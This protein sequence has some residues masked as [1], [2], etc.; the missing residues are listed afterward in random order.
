MAGMQPA[1]A[2]FTGAEPLDGDLP[3]V[4]VTWPTFGTLA[5]VKFET[6]LQ[7]DDGA[8][9]LFINLKNVTLT[10]CR[11]VASAQFVGKVYVL[12]VEYS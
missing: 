4:D 3:Y 12:G 7:V 6:G 10:G 5:N 1:V 9:P 2:P 8:G 11:V